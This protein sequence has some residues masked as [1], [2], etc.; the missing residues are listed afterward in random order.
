MLR[1]FEEMFEGQISKTTVD[2]LRRFLLG[3]DGDDS[4]DGD[5]EA[6]AGVNSMVWNLHA[7]LHQERKERD[8]IRAKASALTKEIRAHHATEAKSK[9]WQERLDALEDEKHALQQLAFGMGN[10]QTIE[11][12]TDQGMLPNYAFPEAPVR[13]TSVIWRRKKKTP[14]S[15]KR[16]DTWSYEYTRSP[17]SALSELAP[18]SDFYAGG[19]KV[20]IDQVDVT[21]A[22]VEE[23]RFCDDCHHAERTALGNE[24]TACSACNSS[25]W[26][27]EGQ[28]FRMLRMRQ[29]FAGAPDRESRIRDDQDDRTPRFFQRQMLVDLNES[30]RLGAWKL[31]TPELPFGFEF[32]TR[33]TF[34]EVNFG[35]F[36]DQGNKT[37]IGGREGVRRGFQICGRC[38][39]VQQQ[40]KDPVHA[41][42]CPSRKPDAPDE[43][44]DCLFLYRDFSS[45]AL[46][47]LLPMADLGTNRQ[48]NSF[49]AALQI[50]LR[51]RFG[52][53]VTHL[54]TTLYS[55][56]EAESSLRRQYLVV[57]DAVPGGTGYLK[58]LVTPTDDSARLPL[59]DA[60]QLALERIEGCE[61]WNDEERDGCYSCLY[62]YR[63]ASDQGDTSASTASEV[64]RKLLAAEPNLTEI[65]ALSE[66]SIKGLMDS[67]L[68]ARFI[69][70]LR[71]IRSG[72]KKAKVKGGM[73]ADK[74]GHLFA[75]GDAHWEVEPQVNVGT[76]EGVCVPT[77]IDFVLR[78]TQPNSS[79]LP[80]AVF[81]DGWAFHRDQIGKDLRQRMAVLASGKWDVWTFTWADIDT[82]LRD[83]SHDVPE[84][85]LPNLGKFKAWMNKLNQPGNNDLGSVSTFGLCE[86]E[87]LGKGPDWSKV[88]QAVLMSRLSA[89][90]PTDG[91]NWASFVST[92]APKCANNW[93]AVTP[94]LAVHDACAINPFF[95]LMAVHDGQQERLLCTLN[96]DPANLE[97]PTF[98]AAWHGYLRLFQLMRHSK[99]AWFMTSQGRLDD[100]H[101]YHAIAARRAGP[102]SSGHWQEFDDID[103]AFQP[104][105]RALMKAGIAEPELGLEIPGAKGRVW[106]NAELVGEDACVA[107]TSRALV[108]DA[109]GATHP[110]WC[111]L[112]IDDLGEDAAPVLQALRNR[113][114]T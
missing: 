62:G 87:L 11:F 60:F 89:A 23:W 81:L 77:S 31:D 90:S 25:N 38:G 46:R 4:D 58:Q 48:L 67:V 3:D 15:G 20:R 98:K 66:V 39:K 56:P 32:L 85:A 26:C 45:E 33:A 40:S 30:D 109:V 57:F 7:R 105:A 78:S 1:E 88:A 28:I 44:E 18:G 91:A 93:S 110:D 108:A 34:R 70:A 106:A 76:A 16:Y 17:S 69:E 52:G 8:S 65:E 95:E 83:V 111:V 47:M 102:G 6:Q 84:L 51:A 54:Q 97:S 55:E 114:G 94:K 72:G 61:C 27:D 12:L 24:L 49:M 21:T 5:N 22:D 13:L 71:Q 82:K 79:Q 99:D 9:Q 80:I 29:V 64:L 107:L 19:R 86:R 104:V 68:E 2:H 96:D 10:R 100:P 43:I 113:E 37:L 50:G 92:A 73:V 35:E 74:P 103:P 14:A 112:Y 42:S 59:F 36:S 75:C 63:N 101:A 53:D 41:L